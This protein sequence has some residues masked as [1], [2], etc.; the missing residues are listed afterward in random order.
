MDDVQIR[1]ANCGCCY[2]DT[3]VGTG[4]ECRYGDVFYGDGIDVGTIPYD[5]P[6]GGIEQECRIKKHNDGCRGGRKKER[7]RKMVKCYRTLSRYFI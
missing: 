7:K 3:D 5:R 4:L 1:S 2:T 6:H